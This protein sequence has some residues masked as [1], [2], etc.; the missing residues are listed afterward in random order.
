MNYDVVGH[1][2][3]IILSL[4]SVTLMEDDGKSQFLMLVVSL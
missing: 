3:T 4:L 1:R 2:M